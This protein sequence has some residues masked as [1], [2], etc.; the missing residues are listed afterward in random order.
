[1]LLTFLNLVV[2]TG[3]LVGIVEG[4]GNQF[5]QKETGDVIITALDTKTYIEKSQ[6]LLSLVAAIP[7]VE[8]VTARSSEGGFIEANYQNGSVPNEKA[9]KTAAV[10]TGIDPVTE[11]AFSG[12][13]NDIREG[14]FLSDG[15]Y[16]SVVL[17]SQ[18]IDRYSF[19]DMPGL[20]PLKNVYPGTRIRLTLNGTTR[21][22]TVK[23]IIVTTANSPL[24]LKVFMPRGELQQLIGRT[25]QNMTEIAIRLSR[26]EDADAVRDLLKR[27]GADEWAEVRTFTDAI[28]N[29]IAEV[30]ATFA[31]IGNAISSIG[32]VVAAI[33]IFIVIFVNAITRRKFIGILKGIGISGK[34]IEL[35]YMFQSLFYAAIGSGVGFAI[36]YGFLVPYISVHPIVLPISNAILVAP[37]DGTIV[38]I[39][40]LVAITV[41]AGY[42][43]ARLIV[44][45]NTLD[46]ILGR[47]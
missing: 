34:A 35:S 5:R 2:V 23:G 36:L 29:G 42:V 1:M 16:D 24:A 28:P 37:L 8:H 27:S 26:P 45:K 12:V 38:R 39:A 6:E 9:N 3:V 22:M 41:I 25:D 40:I 47:A 19:G 13:A 43:P 10:I 20:T 21:E 33:T 46:S 14:S 44:R 7:G 4:I 15:D 31:M 17:G 18:F 32:L 30:R 11:N